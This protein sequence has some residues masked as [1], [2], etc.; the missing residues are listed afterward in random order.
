MS[1]HS[2]EIAADQLSVIA[3][4]TTKDNKKKLKVVDNYTPS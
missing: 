3:V 1:D 2:G 4:D